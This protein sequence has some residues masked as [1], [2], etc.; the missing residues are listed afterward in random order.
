MYLK[1][2]VGVAVVLAAV[3]PV[4]AASTLFTSRSV[5]QATLG[6]SVTDTY[7]S[8]LG[9]GAELSVYTDAQMSAILGET[10]YRSTGFQNTNVVFQMDGDGRYCA[11]CNG[12]FTLDFADTSFSVGGGVFGVGFDIERNDAPTFDALVRFANGTSQLYTLDGSFFGL[13]STLGIASIDFGPDGLVSR[14]G[15]FAIDD[16]VIGNAADTLFDRF[17]NRAA[18]LANVADSRTDTYEPEQGYGSDAL[19]IYTDAQMSAIFGET[20]YTATGFANTNIVSSMGGNSF[21]CAGCNG[22]FLLD[23]ADTSLSK[24]GAVFGVAFDVL[25]NRDL[26]FDAL[27][28][29]GD[30]STR[31]FDLNTGFFGLSSELGVASIAFGIDGQPS[32]VGAF[33]IDN[34]SIASGFSAAPG[35]IPEPATWALM[36]AGFGLVGAAARRRAAATA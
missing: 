3:A 2:V 21:Y 30:G 31:L 9:Y 35:V 23:F 27:V 14:N 15:S 7:Q 32:T 36:M 33:A 24:D 8:E 17:D 1:G 28:T 6:R 25:F 19:N 29:F 26:L 13:T 10:R 18:F 34:L 4:S 11:G 20:R 12:S 5:F 22:S 16:L